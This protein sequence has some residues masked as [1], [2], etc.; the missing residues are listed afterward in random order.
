MKI[1]QSFAQ[2][3]EGSHYLKN[4]YDENYILLSF[5]SFLLSYLTLKKYYGSVTMYCNQKAYDNI[6]KY[7]PYNN[8]VII[9]N[10]SSFEFWSYY[11]IQIMKQMSENFIHVDSDVF[12]FDD[13]FRPF[14]NSSKNDV[15]IQNL[16]PEDRNYASHFV[17][18]N[19]DFLNK[20]N[21]LNYEKYNGRCFSCGVLGITKNIQK[22][23]IEICEKLKKGML[24]MN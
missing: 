12:I 2:F 1:I 5:Y 6:I 23:Y 11:K 17:N 24:I 18:D 9:E 15:I 4:R 3:N 8:I 22:D 13:L 19:K 14:I 10:E 21:I 7:I 16:I 20:N